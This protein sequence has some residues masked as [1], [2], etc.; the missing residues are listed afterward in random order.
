MYCG[1]LRYWVVKKSVYVLK[2]NYI[3]YCYVEMKEDDCFDWFR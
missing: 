3:N 1:I 2:L